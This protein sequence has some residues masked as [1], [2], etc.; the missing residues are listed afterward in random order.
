AFA[1]GLEPDGAAAF[2]CFT[3]ARHKRPP[4]IVRDHRARIAAKYQGQDRVR[5]LPFADCNCHWRPPKNQQASMVDTMVYVARDLLRL[6]I[7]TRTTGLE[8]QGLAHREP[9]K[10]LVHPTSSGRSKTWPAQR[11][12]ALAR[13]LRARGLVPTITVSPAEREAWI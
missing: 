8:S 3:L 2:I 5:F 9:H 13:K 4:A 7:V 12:V 10:V 1:R 6:P 11:F